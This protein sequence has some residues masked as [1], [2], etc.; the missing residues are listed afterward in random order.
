MVTGTIALMLS[1]NPCLGFND[2]KTIF[3]NTAVKI[4]P[5]P[6][7]HAGGRSWQTGYGRID[8]A[9]AVQ[10]AMDQSSFT[11][12]IN[13]NTLLQRGESDTYSAI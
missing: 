9:A 3:K 5:Y 7:T 2:I 8:A 10:S 4:G 6:Y 13:G 11:V 12:T 1:A